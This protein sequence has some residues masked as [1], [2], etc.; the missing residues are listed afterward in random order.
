MK[1]THRG[2]PCDHNPDC[3]NLGPIDIMKHVRKGL[4]DPDT[5]KSAMTKMSADGTTELKLVVWFILTLVYSSQSN[6]N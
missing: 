2:N 5:P 4:I 6:N 1:A 3:I